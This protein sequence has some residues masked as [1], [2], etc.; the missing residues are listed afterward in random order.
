MSTW[1][2][3]QPYY[4]IVKAVADRHGVRIKQMRARDNS[5][6]VCEARR[7]AMT[8]MNIQLGMTCDQ[9]A[10][11]FCRRR[12][13]VNQQINRTLAKGRPQ[14]VKGATRD[15]T[16]D[17][18]NIA[19]EMQKYGHG[20]NA[21]LRKLRCGVEVLERAFDEAGIELKRAR[22]GC[23]ASAGTVVSDPLTDAP[24]GSLPP[25]HPLRAL[26]DAIIRARSAR[27]RAVGGWAQSS[28]ADIV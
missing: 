4:R 5:S 11:V 18:L 10:K 28:L 9:I 14:L 1:N 2:P 16:Q 20:V 21:I 25:D 27:P 19:I 23:R 3:K 12:W 13:T 7:D 26:D 24:I 8:L 17:E 15:L 22:Q 6:K